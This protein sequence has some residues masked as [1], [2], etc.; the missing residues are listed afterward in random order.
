MNC[1][2]EAASVATQRQ[3][4]F[5]IQN[6]NSI[7]S[8]LHE[9]ITCWEMRRA[10]QGVQ[11][12]KMHKTNIQSIIINNEAEGE[13]EISTIV[14]PEEENKNLSANQ[15][16]PPKNPKDHDHLVFPPSPPL[17]QY[18]KMFMKFQAAAA[19]AN[20][21]GNIP[22]LNAAGARRYTPHFSSCGFFSLPISW[23]RGGPMVSDL[24]PA[25]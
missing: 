6:N 21:G 20:R 13:E 9:P 11:N 3:D 22:A 14:P 23:Y 7:P 10:W 17:L 16:P 5:R 12:P 8:T 2:I 1:E 25:E 24:P 18:N 4:V 15:E 19:S